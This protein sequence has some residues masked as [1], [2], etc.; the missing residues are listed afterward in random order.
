ME[1]FD[2]PAADIALG[3]G[4]V[5]LGGLARS[6]EGQLLEAVDDVAGVSPFRHMVTP[7]GHRM[8]VAMTNCGSLGWVTDLTGYRYDRA[9]PVTGR[10][11]PAM[12]PIFCDLAAT[13]AEKAGFAGFVPDACLIN[14]Y[15]VGARLTL[16]QDRNEMDFGAPIVSVS[17]N[18]PAVF[19]WGGLAR[20]DRVRRL[21]L[22]SGDVAVW[23]GPRQD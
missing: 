18:L 14:R 21:R 16:H 15:A 13:A 11:W 8:S 19:L 2:E 22:I 20:T 9:D 3:P 23:G 12:P 10:A 4:A 17:L 5:L 7:G 1:L 6:L